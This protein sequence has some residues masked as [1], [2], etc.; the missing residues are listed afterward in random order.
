MFFGSGSGSASMAICISIIS[1][2]PS[3]KMVINHPYLT[4]I[5]NPLTFVNHIHHKKMEQNNWHYP[6]CMI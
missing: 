4:K 2:I 3:I 6:N 1:Q 5:H